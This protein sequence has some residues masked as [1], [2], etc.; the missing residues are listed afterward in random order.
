MSTKYEKMLAYHELTKRRVN[1]A[2]S[3][4]NRIKQLSDAELQKILDEPD[5]PEEDAL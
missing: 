1:K 5:E 3:E 2:I 4:E